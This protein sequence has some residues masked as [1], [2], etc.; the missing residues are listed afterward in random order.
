MMRSYLSAGLLFVAVATTPARADD[1]V[2]AIEQ[3]R[4]AYQSGDMTAAKQSLDLASQLIAQKN[5]EGYATVLPEP[6][7]GWKADK[8]QTSAVGAAVFGGVSAATRTY[9]NAKGDTVE[10]SISGDSALLMQF[11]PMLN[12][13]A[14]AGALGKLIR[15][16]NQRAVQNPDGDVMMIVA[17]KFLINVQG[18]ADSASKVAYAQA[19]DIAKLSKL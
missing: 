18:T 3:G 5:A 7:S 10:I 19:I 8:A 11:A 6:L 15:I 16:G 13:P 14:M 2:D 17:N 1:I 9:T 12:N 4:K